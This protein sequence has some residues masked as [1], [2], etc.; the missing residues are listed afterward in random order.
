MCFLAKVWS[1]PVM[2][3]WGKKKTGRGKEEGWPS[4]IQD[5]KNATR[6]MRSFTQDPRVLRLSKE[7]AF[8]ISGTELLRKAVYMES[9]SE[10]M[11]ISP[12][13]ALRISERE[14]FTVERRRLNLTISCLSTV[15][16]DNSRPFA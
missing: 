3:P 11:T 12:L 14:A 9:R 7:T 5:R 1:V 10:D 2:N 13:I 15:A 16:K 6:L 8:Q 4:E